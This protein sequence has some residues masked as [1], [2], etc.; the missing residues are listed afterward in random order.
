[1]HL[2]VELYPSLDSL[3]CTEVMITPVTTVCST[4]HLIKTQR[5]LLG[6]NLKISEMILWLKKPLCQHNNPNE[7]KSNQIRQ[8]PGLIDTSAPGWPS[9]TPRDGDRKEDRKNIE[10]GKEDQEDHV[11]HVFVLWESI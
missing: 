11:F 6:L 2:A 5:Q 1:M 10:K 4:A 9:R 8:S 3:T 7:N